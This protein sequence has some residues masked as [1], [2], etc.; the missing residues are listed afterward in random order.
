MMKKQLLENY[1]LENIDSAFRFAYTYTRN[2][3]E[4]EDVVSESVIKAL[5]SVK[6]LKEEKNIKPWFYKIIVNT[7]LT[8]LKRN[9]KVVYIDYDEM[10]ELNGRE[11]DYSYL[12]FESMIKNLDIKYKEII[13]MRFFE[14]MPIKE[15]SQVLGINE[16]TVKT[17]LYSGLKKLKIQLEGDVYE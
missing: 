16:N 14:N 3:E 12:S 7:A 8:H 5:K 4:A 13:V 1:L 6:S 15:I 11:D 9:S 10:G 17:R 2:R